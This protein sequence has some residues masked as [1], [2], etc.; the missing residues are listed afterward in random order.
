MTFVR[1]LIVSH[2]LMLLTFA[3]ESEDAVGV[4]SLF[5]NHEDEVHAVEVPSNGKVSDIRAA[6]RQIQAMKSVRNHKWCFTFS[7]S[8]L[9]DDTSLAESGVASECTLNVQVKA[10]TC[11]CLLFSDLKHECRGSCAR[12]G[13]DESCGRRGTRGCGCDRLVTAGSEHTCVKFCEHLGCDSSCPGAVQSDIR[14]H[15]DAAN[16]RQRAKLRRSAWNGGTRPMA[17]RLVRK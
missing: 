9:D 15:R 12:R 10:T 8:D 17:H 4:L 13:C 2:V 5:I 7:G 3:A 6:S 14:M 16:R 1:I 11:G